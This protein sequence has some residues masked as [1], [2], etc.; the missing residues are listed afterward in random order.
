LNGRSVARNLQP[1][2]DGFAIKG[3]GGVPKTCQRLSGSRLSQGD[4][5]DGQEE[6]SQEFGFHVGSLDR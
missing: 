1:E 6:S 2:R 3:D 5:R 4:G